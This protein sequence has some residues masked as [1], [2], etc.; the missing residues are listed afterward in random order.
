MVGMH[1]GDW[2]Q[3]VWAGNPNHHP[4]DTSVKALRYNCHMGMQVGK[5]KLK[6]KSMMLAVSSIYDVGR[7][8]NQSFGILCI[9]QY[10]TCIT[11]YDMWVNESIIMIREGFEL[12]FKF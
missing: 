12:I 5:E 3:G 8:F 4:I 6:W 2:S 10:I 9:F 1:V 7:I 11:R